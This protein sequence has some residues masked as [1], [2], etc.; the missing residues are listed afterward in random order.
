[1]FLFNFFLKIFT[2]TYYYFINNLLQRII[3]YFINNKLLIL[4]INTLLQDLDNGYN[5]IISFF[6][7]KKGVNLS[8]WKIIKFLI[9]KVFIIKF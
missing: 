3:N 4:L 5:Y 8:L 2:K 9:Y 1:M 7:F 6:F